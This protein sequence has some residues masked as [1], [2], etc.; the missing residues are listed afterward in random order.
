MYDYNIWSHDA[1][2]KYSRYYIFIGTGNGYN[3]RRDKFWQTCLD[4][5]YYD[6]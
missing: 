2:V 5:L 6:E 1:E 4:Y 3:T